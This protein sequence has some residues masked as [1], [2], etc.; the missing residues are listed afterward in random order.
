MKKAWCLILI[1][2][3]LLVKVHAVSLDQ[4]GEQIK[5]VAEKADTLKESIS[6]K[7][8]K[9]RYLR[10]EWSNFIEKIP[11]LGKIHSFFVGH[12]LIFKI[13]SNEPYSFSLV[14]FLTIILWIYIVIIV[15][16]LLKSIDLVKESY[17]VV[18]G[19]SIAVILSQIN[20]RL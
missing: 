11:I 4:S 6:P 13:L 1:G 16:N 18:F 9:N 2:I 12:P 8:I 10:Q 14:F 17:T 7:E 15:S 5:S 3:L 19:I 20:R